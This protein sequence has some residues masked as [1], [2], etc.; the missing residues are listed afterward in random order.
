MSAL[1]EVVA[2]VHGSLAP[3]AVEQPEPGGYEQRLSAD[4]AF[5]IEA[6][7]EGFLMHYR[8]PRSF[9]AEMDPDLR[10]LAGDSLY[11]LGLERLAEH[12]DLAAVAEL[13]DLISGCAQAQAEDRPDA[14]EALWEA[15]VATLARDVRTQV[16]G[17]VPADG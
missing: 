3:F 15:S 17:K 9:A 2:A 1:A 16:D 8:E 12:G 14:T 4:R 6:V 7:Y 11:A 13:A 5:T 10:L